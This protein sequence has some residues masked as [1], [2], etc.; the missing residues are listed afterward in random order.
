MNELSRAI[1]Q[2]RDRYQIKQEDFAH[3]L[4]VSQGSVSLWEKGVVYPKPRMVQRIKQ[5]IEEQAAF[6]AEEQ[7]SRFVTNALHPLL[8]LRVGQDRITP[9]AFSTT[10]PVRYVEGGRVPDIFIDRHLRE[11][12]KPD[13]LGSIFSFSAPDFGEFHECRMNLMR[14]DNETLILCEH[15]RFGPMKEFGV[16]PDFVGFSPIYA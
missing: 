10:Y 11:I 2:F 15:L 6:T 7:M 13:F 3:R 16:A 14:F 1:R 5:L 9:V 12:K 4:G 8:L